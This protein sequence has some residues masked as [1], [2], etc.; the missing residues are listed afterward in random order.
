ME[1]SRQFFIDGETHQVFTRGD[2][3]YV[4]HLER[5]GGKHGVMNLTKKAGSRTMRE[6]VR[7]VVDYHQSN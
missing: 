4:D 7:A 5:S 3:V 2:Q 1:I 6:G